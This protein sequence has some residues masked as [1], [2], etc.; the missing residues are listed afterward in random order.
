MSALDTMA[1]QLAISNE[2]LAKLHGETI[3]TRRTLT[4]VNVINVLT[5]ITL[6]ALII[7]GGLA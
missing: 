3:R 4:A 2:L 7:R 1:E 5:L 6:L